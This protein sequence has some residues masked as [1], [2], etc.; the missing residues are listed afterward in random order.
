[1]KYQPNIE[2]MPIDI[3]LNEYLAEKGEE[4]NL[5]LPLLQLEAE[6]NGVAN[7]EI[8]D[9]LFVHLK[10]PKFDELRRSIL[11]YVTRVLKL[12]DRKIDI[13][14]LSE[15]VSMLQTQ[16]EQ[17][18]QHLIQQGIEQGVEQ[19]VKQG[20]QQGEAI[21]LMRLL[22]RKFGGV[23]ADYRSK[24]EKA[25]PELILSWAEGVLEASSLESLFK[26]NAVTLR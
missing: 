10:N 19:G 13:N 9:R 17:W 3:G 20:E 12:G 8:V 21:V 26:L 7:A 24:I 1:L 11:Q 4:A 5:L 6:K 16:V 14:H 22:Q 18:K 15:E 25:D 2:Y 23:P